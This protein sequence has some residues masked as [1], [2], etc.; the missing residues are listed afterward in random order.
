MA[1]KKKENAVPEI[2]DNVEALEAKDESNERSSEKICYLHT[3]TGRQ[4]LFRSS[5]GSK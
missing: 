4:N 5:D 1:T 3:G 2:I